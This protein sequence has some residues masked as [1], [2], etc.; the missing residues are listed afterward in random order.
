MRVLF[1]S[2][3]LLT[4]FISCE[5]EEIP[6]PPHTIG[7][8]FFQQVELGQ[9]YRYQVFYDLG[10][11]SV[12]SQNIKTD[13]DLGFESSSQGFHIKLNSS[14]YSSLSYF[15]NAIFEDTFTIDNLFWSWDNPNGSLDSTAFGDYRA[16]ERIYIIDRGFDLNGNQRG[17]K[18][19]V[20]DTVTDS[21]YLIR[22]ADLD[23]SDLY[24]FQ[25]NKTPDV[26]FTSF[27]F[28]DNNILNIE[29][30]KLDWD[31]LFSQYTHLY[32]DTSVP[33]YVVT[34]VLSNNNVNISIDTINAFEDISYNMINSSSFDNNQNTIGFNWKEY[35]LTSGQYTIYSNFNYIIK[36]HESKYYKLRFL[37][38]YNDLGVKG[39]PKFEIQEL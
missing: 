20:I 27:S 31:L 11:N 12:V 6:I 38:F 39:Y 9:D 25:V 8:V 21:Y 17:Y 35:D 36:D 34:G 14:T 7:D 22:Y 15:E 16:L 1:Y 13:W 5:K 23:N 29:P 28:S 18:K 37:D 3:V 10:T 30:S 24:T 19:M 2:I 26:N 4:V 32:S 33:S